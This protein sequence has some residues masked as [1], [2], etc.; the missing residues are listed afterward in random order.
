MTFAVVEW[1]DQLLMLLTQ[2]FPEGTMLSHLFNVKGLLA[3]LLVCLICGV[4]GALVVGNRMAF[5]SDALAH[6]AFAGVGFGLLICLVTDTAEEH[7]RQ[8]ITIIMVLFGIGIGMMIAFVREKTGLA[9]DTVIGV[10]YAV[11]IGLAAISTRLVSGKRFFNIES[12]IFGDP[13]FTQTWEIAT[14]CVLAGCILVFLHFK[15]NDLILASINPSLAQSRRIQVRFYQYWLIILLGLI[16]NLSQQ[17]VGTLLINGLLIVPAATAANLA[18]NLREMFWLSVALAM[19]AG[20]V[21]YWLSWEISC[22]LPNQMRVGTS[23][24]IIVLSGLMFALSI[25]WRQRPVA[26][27]HV[28][29]E[30][31]GHAH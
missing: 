11:S 30:S 3:T 15:Y 27:T 22:N 28:H 17:I 25:R 31:C 6:C 19:S 12:F 20:L 8:N 2:A 9:S 23:G 18:R 10:F 14:L 16:V 26:T 21:G 5:F 24:T 29:D 7:F 13:I 4:T 1:L